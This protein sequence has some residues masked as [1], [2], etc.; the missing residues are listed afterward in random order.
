ML[1]VYF[2]EIISSVAIGAS[3][4]FLISEELIIVVED[5]RSFEEFRTLLFL[6]YNYGSLV[7]P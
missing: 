4:S 1:I 6:K 3:I 7:L 5:G 2:G